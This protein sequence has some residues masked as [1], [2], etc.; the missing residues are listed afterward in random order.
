MAT[1]CFIA[2]APAQAVGPT[3]WFTA[4][5][6]S[7]QGL[8]ASK[9]NNQSI[10][11]VAHLS[12]GGS[13]VRIRLQNTFG[14][15]PLII[16]RATVG[17]SGK[18]ATLVD[19]ARPITFAGGRSVTIPPGGELWSDE[20]GLDT[21][22]QDDVAV[23]MYVAGTVVP[24]QH[25]F[26]A[27]DNYLTPPGTGDHTAES[28]GSAYTQTVVSTYLVSAVDVHNPALQGT[29]VGFGSSVV[30]GV[31][32]TN[33]GP[34]CTELGA[35][36]RWLDDLGRRISAELPPGEQLAVANAGIS[37]TTS[38][39]ECPS[40]PQEAAGLDA[41]ARL[42][43][44][45]LALH[46]VTGVIY[47]Y[48]TNDLAAGCTAAQILDSYHK[49]FQRL[50]DAGIAVHVTPITPRPSYTDRQNLDR[51]TVGTF[52]KRWNNCAGTCDDVIDFDQVL[53]DPLKPNSIYPP[54][55]NGDG[56]HA[57][58]AGQQALADYVCLPALRPGS[59]GQSCVPL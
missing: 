15:Q 47:Y 39:G 59:K 10:R 1:V 29:V 8:A 36:R 25:A 35:N 12:Q 24:G 51:H 43:R 9:L 14:K 54:Y 41:L 37:A 3:S 57:N 53:K 17:R 31:G 16:D 42:D 19:T 48:G 28:S 55:D 44:D 32:S 23:S 5:A 52:V 46:G 34:G 58:I 30:D 7:Q 49:V 4:W 33:C 38:S 20:T 40:I 26:A 13:A 22:P 27:R 45:V 18:D 50:R 11:M 21:R 56:A 2:S 6:Q